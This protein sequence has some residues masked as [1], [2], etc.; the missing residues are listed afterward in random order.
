[1][2]ERKRERER[3]RDAQPRGE[4]K[5]ERNE[6]RGAE[7]DEKRV[8]LISFF[9]FFSLIFVFLFVNVFPVPKKRPTVSAS[10]ERGLPFF[11]LSNVSKPFF[12]FSF[13]FLHANFRGVRKQEKKKDGEETR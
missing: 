10:F 13:S 8:F 4:R 12:F 3:E 5:R 11:Y 1:M 7:G 9:I 6:E 2:N